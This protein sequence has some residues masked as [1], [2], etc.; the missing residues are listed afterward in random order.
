MTYFHTIFTRR[1]KKISKK[2][3][4]RERGKGGIEK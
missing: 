2:M 3:A 4:K 1:K